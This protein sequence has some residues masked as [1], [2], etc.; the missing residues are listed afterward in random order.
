MIGRSAAL[1]RLRSLVE[2]AELHSSDLPTIA[3]IAGEAGIGKTRLL[4]EMVGTLPSDV[5]VF[6]AVAEPR[7]LGRSFDVASQLA[8]ASAVVDEA[9]EAS[10]D[11][12]SAAVAAI[13]VAAERGR[14]AVLI[15]DL[16]WIDAESV[17]V[18][19]SIARQPWPN[20]VIFATYRP[21]DLSRGAPGGDLVLRLERRNEVEQFRLDRL[22]RTEVGALMSAIGGRL[23]SSAAVEAVYRRSGGVPFVIEELLR[24]AGPDACSD[25]LVSA[26]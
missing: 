24:C 5:T 25:D 6:S 7:S 23:V 3:L 14:V 17:G 13:G 8:P 2:L 1:E 22:T 15:E 21:S 18:I 20:V 4:R 16:H 11:P 26:R 12:A 19:D 9:S 10:D